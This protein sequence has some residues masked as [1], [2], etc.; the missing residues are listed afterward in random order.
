ML[1][2]A[3]VPTL[4]TLSLFLTSSLEASTSAR[5]LARLAP[6]DVWCPTGLTFDEN[7]PGIQ[8]ST[9]F[10]FDRGD[11]ETGFRAPANGWVYVTLVAAG[12]LSVD[13][14][15]LLPRDRYFPPSAGFFDSDTCHRSGDPL[16]P[17]VRVHPFDASA[18]PPGARLER[19]AITDIEPLQQAG[20]QLGDAVLDLTESAVELL[21]AADQAAVTATCPGAG[22]GACPDATGSLFLPGGTRVRFPMPVM[23]GEDYVLQLWWKGSVGARLEVRVDDFSPCPEE[24][25][26]FFVEHS[27]ELEVE[28]LGAELMPGIDPEIFLLFAL[29][30]DQSDTFGKVQIDGSTHDIPQIDN[31]DDPKWQG[32]ARFAASNLSDPSAVPIRIELFDNDEFD[33]AH[34]DLDPSPAD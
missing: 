18:L 1:R 14:I 25:E 21:G 24:P 23:A 8:S 33:N 2:T 6:G 11:L 34:V 19:F 32:A 16:F 9:P 3:W 26:G 22:A 7:R 28:I 20:W 30:E 15:L 10:V 12:D 13:N 17:R 27:S 31:D 4:L 29:I 5:S